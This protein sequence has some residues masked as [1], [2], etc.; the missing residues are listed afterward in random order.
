MRKIGIGIVAGLLTAGAA[1]S[2]SPTAASAAPQHQNAHLYAYWNFHGRTGFW[3]VDQQVRVAKKAPASYW[4][5]NFGFTAT[6]N[7]GGYMGLQTNGRRF[8]GTSGDTAIFSLWNATATRGPNCGRFGGE[9]TG[10]SC[11]VGFTINTGTYY[12]YRVW[13]LDADS[14]GQWWGAWI[15]NPVTGKDTPIGQ[16]RVPRNKRLMTTPMNFS[17]YFG[18]A[19]TCNT[20]P[21]SKA[22]FTQP[23]A[24]SRGGGSYEHGS[25][26]A[27]S[28]RGQCTGGSVRVVRVGSTKA[29]AITM[30][31]RR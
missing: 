2:G 15:A 7:E 12:R 28:H 20:V 25:V 27:S 24:N 4:A 3:N 1:L 18:P 14:R 21:V 5:M 13:R 22:Y 29:A 10:M 9:G 30:G 19:R 8:N 31:G 23:A 6:P 11:R 26:F 16:I 17:E